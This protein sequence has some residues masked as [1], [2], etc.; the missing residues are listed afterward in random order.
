MGSGTLELNMADEELVASFAGRPLALFVSHAAS[1][2]LAAGIL[3]EAAGV[4]IAI[5]TFFMD[6]GVELLRDREWVESL[7]P[8]RY[9][10]CDVS[11]KRRGIEPPDRIIA[12]GQYQNAIM[13]H[14]AGR[15]VSL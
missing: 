11:A 14:D 12:G 3:A 10:A 9:A 7:P 1:R 2:D 6:E 4:G 5:T 13:I 15:V 8:G